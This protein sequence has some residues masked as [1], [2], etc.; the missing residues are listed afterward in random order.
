MLVNFSPLAGAG[1]Q[2]FDN[3]GVPL[4]GG[5]L[6][7]Y[8][9]GTTTPLPTYT[10]STG[11][12]ANEN[13]IILDSAGRVPEQIWLPNGYST[14]FVLKNAADVLI[15]TKDN[16][17]A[18]PQPPIVNDASSIT[19]DSG[20]SVTAGSFIIGQT[21]VITSIGS[22]NFQSI[23]AVSN[24]VG[25]YFIATGVGSGS[26]T[27]DFIRTVQTKLR[28]SVSVKDFGA[29]GDGV[30]DDTAAI[31]A[32]IDSFSGSFK[33]GIVNFP[34][35]IYK[36]S[37]LILTGEVSLIG[38]GRGSTISQI[39]GTVGALI[40]WNDTSSEV[41]YP[42]IVTIEG[43][44]LEGQGVSSGTTDND[45]ILINEY[46]GLQI[47]TLKNL[48][49]DGFKGC[50]INAYQPR[51]NTVANAYQF[52]SWS[53]IYIKNCTT[54]FRVGDGFCG[55]SVLTNVTFQNI[56]SE[57]VKV[58]IG[59]F[60]GAQGITF[61]SCNFS[62]TPIGVNFTAGTEG[63]FSF[64][65]CHF[66]NMGTEAVYLSTSQYN[67]ISFVNCWFALT[68]VSGTSYGIRDNGTGT[69]RCSITNCTWTSPS[70]VSAYI[71]AEA[72]S[73]FTLSVFGTNDARGTIPASGIILPSTNS[74]TGTVNKT[75]L[76]TANFSVGVLSAVGYYASNITFPATQV[77]SADVNTLDDYE[78]GDTFS[79]TLTA[80]ANCSSVVITSGVYTK[81]G[82]LVYLKLSGTF[83]ITGPGAD[84]GFTTTLPF[85]QRE[86]AEGSVGTAIHSGN[87]G[88]GG[89]G[90]VQDATAGSSA[91]AFV[92]FPAAGV[93]VSGASKT[94]SASITYNSAT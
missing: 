93:T 43:F 11:S 52:S 20:Y 91:T 68:N 82:R 26:G 79:P 51:S 19:Y 25:I 13:P 29:I 32:A 50:G 71:K 86:N 3:N 8:F 41:G 23:G 5:L 76:T 7:T 54:G 45:A 6:Y 27:A 1:A 34:N 60:A 2:F 47:L 24:T 49:I 36:V 44:T 15:W 65:E 84:T 83:T 77:S 88:Y 39:A 10:S 9:A 69:T 85:A 72:G 16:I 90:Y 63:L 30:A 42:W 70:G 73:N 59:V 46:W 53:D 62:L 48:Y 37:T 40:K 55:E 92:A 94:W 17:P 58:V 18:S 75:S 80:V 33:Q 21:Y 35:G 74:V 89:F 14:K 38:I 64:N 4:A 56:V 31:Q 57:C 61:N 78:E 67:A 22:T 12:T 81:I 28:E 87:A 66:E